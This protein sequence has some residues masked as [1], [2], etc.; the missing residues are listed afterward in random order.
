MSQNIEQ[1]PLLVSRSE[2]MASAILL[3]DFLHIHGLKCTH[4]GTGIAHSYPFRAT[5]RSHLIVFRCC[6]CQGVYNLYSATV[7]E[8]RH[9]PPSQVVHL[10]RGIAGEKSA[11]VLASEL[12]ISRTTATELRHLLQTEIDCRRLADLFNGAGVG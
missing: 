12:G 2:E 5:K 6:E 1:P 4:C 9:L 8:A 11:A 3:Y 7:F 10:I